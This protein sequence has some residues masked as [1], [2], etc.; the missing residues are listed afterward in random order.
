MCCVGG[1]LP[2]I[3]YTTTKYKHLYM[4]TTPVYI[5]LENKN[6]LFLYQDKNTSSMTIDRSSLELAPPVR[7]CA[8][9]YRTKETA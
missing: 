2:H 9:V 8:V 3:T 5:C 4:M 1:L 7:I 6:H